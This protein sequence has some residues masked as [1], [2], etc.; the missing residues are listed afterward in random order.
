MSARSISAKF[1]IFFLIA[2]VQFILHDMHVLRQTKFH[3]CVHRVVIALLY[4]SCR[5]VRF[6]YCCVVAGSWVCL[7]L[8]AYKKHIHVQKCICQKL[9]HLVQRRHNRPPIPC[10]SPIAAPYYKRRLVK[11]LQYVGQFTASPCSLLVLLR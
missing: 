7:I 1:Q 2:S 9:F 4:S 11:D 3:N 8:V 5:N 10:S 6:F